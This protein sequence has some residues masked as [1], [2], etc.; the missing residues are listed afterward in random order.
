M[1]DMYYEIRLLKLLLV[2]DLQI[3]LSSGCLEV[4]LMV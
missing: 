1:F 4:S 2:R 3:L